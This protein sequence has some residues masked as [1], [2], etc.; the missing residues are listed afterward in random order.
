MTTEEY[1]L[2]E[3]RLIEEESRRKGI[4]PD[5]WISQNALAYHKKHACSITPVCRPW[6]TYKNKK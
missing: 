3:E 1:I 6:F 2:K 4:G 5:E